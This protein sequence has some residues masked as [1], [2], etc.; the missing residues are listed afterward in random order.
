MDRA[1]E[2]VAQTARDR[3]VPMPSSDAYRK[4]QDLLFQE[5]DEK[6][7]LRD[8]ALSQERFESLRQR[9]Q[10]SELS[11]DEKTALLKS[12]K[13]LSEILEYLDAS[14][15]DLTVKRIMAARVAIGQPISEDQAREIYASAVRSNS[16]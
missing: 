10:A 6:Q 12:G 16:K 3:I 7:R 4:A 15:M 2:R 5:L 8:Q 14:T 9:M 1:L 13:T 11:M